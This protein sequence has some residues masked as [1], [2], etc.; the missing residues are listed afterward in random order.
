MT[1]DIMTPSMPPHYESTTVIGGRD[2]KRG[3]LWMIFAISLAIVIAIGFLAGHSGRPATESPAASAVLG[4]V[5]LDMTSGAPMIQNAS[6]AEIRNP[7]VM[8]MDKST[9]T[10]KSAYVTVARKF[11]PGERGSV[12]GLNL[13]GLTQPSCAVIDLT[14]ITP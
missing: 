6:Q 8:C 11:T 13:T 7:E 5:K 10:P 2:T 4:Q 14:V 9:P 3:F 1:S 12:D